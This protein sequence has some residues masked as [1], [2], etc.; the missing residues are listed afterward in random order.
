MLEFIVTVGL[1]FILGIVLL[2]TFLME[3]ILGL[4]ALGYIGYVFYITIK[5]ENI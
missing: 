2:T 5:D 4:A 3:I 1:I